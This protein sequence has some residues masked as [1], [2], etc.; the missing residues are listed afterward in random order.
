M[1][2]RQFHDA[3]ITGGSMPIEMVRAHLTKQA[4]PRDF[5]TSWL[6]AGPSPVR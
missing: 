4:L 5:K 3:I 2:N 6:Y 1:T